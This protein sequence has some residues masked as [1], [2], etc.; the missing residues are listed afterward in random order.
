LAAAASVQRS[1]RGVEAHV[2]VEP[3]GCRV[4]QRLDRALPRNCAGDRRRDAVAGHV[5][6]LLV[7]EQPG[8]G[9][10]LATQAGV[11]PLLGDALELTEEVQLRVAARIAPVV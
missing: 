1:R 8:I 10:A 4:E 6:Q 7:H 9:V 2:R 11:E 5:G 3:A